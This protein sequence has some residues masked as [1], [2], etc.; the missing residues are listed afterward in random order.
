MSRQVA[1]EGHGLES[2]L[3]SLEQEGVWAFAGRDHSLSS[4][5]F[6]QDAG[7][8]LVDSL[9]TGACEDD[10]QAHRGGRGG[11]LQDGFQS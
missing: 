4:R 11:L 2:E 5:A 1:A 9:V 7:S 10:S 3:Q 6:R 8:A